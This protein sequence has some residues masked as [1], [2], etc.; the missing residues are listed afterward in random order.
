MDVT[1]GDRQHDLIL[2]TAAAH[3]IR[4]YNSVLRDKGRYVMVGGPAGR[5]VK[6]QLLGPLFSRISGKQIGTF[7]LEVSDT[8]LSTVAD[9]LA[10]ETVTPVIDRTFPLEETPAAMRYLEAGR[11]CGKVVIVMDDE[12]Q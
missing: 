1:A 2:D 6:V 9:H 5:F 7:E 10:A 3:S 8:D 12:G 4:A 11:A